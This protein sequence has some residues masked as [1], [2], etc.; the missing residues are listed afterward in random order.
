ML[1]IK[2]CICFGLALIFLIVSLFIIDDDYT[3]KK[4]ND[5]KGDIF[6]ILCTSFVGS[7]LTIKGISLIWIDS[8]PS[9][10]TLE[11]YTW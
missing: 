4:K 3:I 5:E 8:F 1:W 2:L 11:Y 9:I 10:A 6:I 7:Y